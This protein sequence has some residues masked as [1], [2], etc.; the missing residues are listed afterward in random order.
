MP[1]ARCKQMHK[2]CRQDCEFAQL[3]PDDGDEKFADIHD[4]FGANNFMKMLKRLP[5]NEQG[6]AFQSMAYEAKMRRN[7]QIH[8]CHGKIRALEQ[9]VE[10][11]KRQLANNEEAAQSDHNPSPASTD[12]KSVV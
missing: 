11:L 4:V 8:G 7:D 10:K 12:R 6:D 5:E 9:E 2:E 1:C 3:F